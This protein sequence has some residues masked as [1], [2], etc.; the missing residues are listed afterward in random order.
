VRVE[1]PSDDRYGVIV[2]HQEGRPAAQ[3]SDEDC[4][5]GRRGARSDLLR[6][7]G[8]GLHLIDVAYVPVG[9][10]SHHWLAADDTG[11]RRWITVD[12]LNKKR[13]LGANRDAAFE[14]LRRAFD[15]AVALCESGLE[16]VLA[17]PTAA[18]KPSAGSVPA[19][20]WLC[21]R[22]SRG[23]LTSSVL[24]CPAPRPTSG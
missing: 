1:K 21:S 9:F 16:F 11:A 22:A 23:P 4:S 5:R 14:G 10:G 12:E 15:T 3:R 18:G 20:R 6:V 24:G 17:P 2:L 7:S 8:R 13:Y 19:T